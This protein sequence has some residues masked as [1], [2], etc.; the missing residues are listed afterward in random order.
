MDRCLFL[1]EVSPLNHFEMLIPWHHF[2]ILN[3]RIENVANSSL[4]SAV[5]TESEFFACLG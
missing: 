1:L 4:F 2:S 3:D 5:L